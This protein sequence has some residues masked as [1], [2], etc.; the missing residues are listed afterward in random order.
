MVEDIIL[1]DVLALTNIVSILFAPNGAFSLLERI[2][3]LPIQLRNQE[4]ELQNPAH[5]VFH[6]FSFMTGVVLSQDQLCPQLLDDPMRE[7]IV[8]E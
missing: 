3:E 7:I 4:D 2:F 8:L 1:E 6:C 5:P